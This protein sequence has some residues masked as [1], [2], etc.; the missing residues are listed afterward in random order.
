MTSKY[1]RDIT[2]TII[3]QSLEGADLNLITERIY[4]LN[5]TSP[6]FRNL[7]YHDRIFWKQLF[8]KFGLNLDDKITCPFRYF[9]TYQWIECLYS[10][11]YMWSW[12]GYGIFKH[13]RSYIIT[14]GNIVCDKIAVD[15]NYAVIYMHNTMYLCHNDMRY[16]VPVLTN[17]MQGVNIFVRDTNIGVI[18]GITTGWSMIPFQVLACFTYDGSGSFRTLDHLCGLWEELL[19]RYGYIYERKYYRYDASPSCERIARLIQN[20][21]SMVCSTNNINVIS[22]INENDSETLVFEDTGEDV[23]YLDDESDLD[24]AFKNHN[25]TRLIIIDAYDTSLP[26]YDLP[27]K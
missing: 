1:P 16:G 27:E 15:G 6:E 2:R 11:K 25:K 17:L 22:I 19:F 7:L 5:N 9:M 4:T 3:L 20:E 13:N 14:P 23:T 26:T 24:T 8:A 12:R 10:D 18:F 21:E